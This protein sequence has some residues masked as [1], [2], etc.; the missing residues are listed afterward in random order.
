MVRLEAGVLLKYGILRHDTAMLCSHIA[1][2]LDDDHDSLAKAIAPDYLL[3]YDGMA[4]ST[5][6]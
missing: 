4:F 6:K 5:T 1:H 2:Y 3:A